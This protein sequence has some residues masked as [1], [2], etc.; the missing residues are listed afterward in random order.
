MFHL[1]LSKKKL[2]EYTERDGDRD[3]EIERANVECGVNVPRHEKAHRVLK[4][5]CDTKISSIQYT[6]N[7]IYN[8]YYSCFLRTKY[9]GIDIDCLQQFLSFLQLA[10]TKTQEEKSS[11]TS[12]DQQHT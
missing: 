5:P 9:M 6:D 8:T 12:S 4:C 1:I 3:I 2:S 7:S 11:S 10:K